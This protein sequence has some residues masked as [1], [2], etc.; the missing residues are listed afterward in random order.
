MPKRKICRSFAVKAKLFFSKRSCFKLGDIHKACINYKNLL[1]KEYYFILGKNQKETHIRLIFSK[2]EFYH[3][4]GLHKLNDIIELNNP[5]KN[6]IFDNIFDNK[7]TSD[8]CNKSSHYSEINERIDLIEN[9][10]SFLDSNKT[11]F[12][13]N[14]HNKSFSL[15]E[16]DYILKNNDIARNKYVF[17][18]REDK[19]SDTYFCRSAFSRDKS[20]R[21]YVIGHTSYTLLYKEKVDLLTNEKQVLYVHPSYKK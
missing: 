16:A 21:D 19:N 11:I 2:I 9:L 18:S 13:Y 1:N 15:I 8:L 4:C 10:E 3:I 5:N 6:Q 12:K 14:N 17:I 7:I 20:E